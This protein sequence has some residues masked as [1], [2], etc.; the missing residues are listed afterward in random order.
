MRICDFSD[1]RSDATSKET[2]KAALNELIDAYSNPKLIQRLTRECHSSL[3]DMFAINVFRPLP[4]I[5]R[6]LLYSDEVTFEDSA[7]SHLSLI[8]I[9]FLKFL[10][11]NIDQRILQ[12]Q[13]T[14]RFITQLFA[15]LDF[16]D[17]RER[18]QAKAVISAIFNKV[19]PQRLFSFFL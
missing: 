9:L 15:V 18:N 1:A 13:L 14:P 2:K 10:E 11:A 19:P 7:W 17:E 4:N 16:P 3:I 8:Y 6:A 12:F 5:P